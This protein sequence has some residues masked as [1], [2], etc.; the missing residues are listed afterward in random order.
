MSFIQK[1]A[2][3]PDR[4]KWMLKPVQPEVH[5]TYA[6]L[7]INR[8]YMYSMPDVNVGLFKIQS[9]QLCFTQAKERQV[10]QIKL[11]YQY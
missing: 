4:A 10:L 8:L 7:Q 5:V 3:F 1:K 11:Q 6:Q 9:L 2:I